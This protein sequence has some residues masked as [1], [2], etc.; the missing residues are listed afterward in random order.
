MN[1]SFRQLVTV[2]A[3]LCASAAFGQNTST[4]GKIVAGAATC[5]S[6][7]CVYYQLPPATPWVVVTVS[8]TWSGTINLAS[9]SAPNANYYNLNSLAWNQ[10]ASTTANGSWSI[11]TGGATFLLIY[12]P[13][14]SSGAASVTMTSSQTGSPLSNPVFLGAITGDGFIS[15]APS[16][17]GSTPLLEY[18]GTC[19]AGTPGSGITSI[20][21]ALPS[22]LSASPSTLNASGTQTFASATGL[23][24]HEVIGT[25]GTATTVSLCA[26]TLG[27]IGA[28]AAPSGLYDFSSASQLKHPVAAGYTS[29]AN[30]E[31]GY[32]STNLNWH[33]WQNGVDMLF[34]FLPTSGL[35]SGDCVEFLKTTNSWSLED[36]GAACGSGGGG[37]NTALSNLASVNIN[38]A[39][40]PQTSIDLG[41]TTKPFRNLY[42]YGSSTYGTDYFELTG[43]PTSTRTWT[44]QDATD[45]VVGRAT[46]DALTNKSIAATE[47][48]SGTLAC[49]QMPA[50]TGDATSSAGACATTVVQIEGAAIPTSAAFVATNGSKQFVAAAYTPA[51]CT[52]GTTGSDCLQLSSGLVPTGNL[53]GYVADTTVTIGSSVAFSA[54]ACSS[55]TGVSG[56]ASTVSMSGLATTMT[57]T[58]TPNSDVHSVTGW[59]PASGGQLYFTAWPSASGTLSYYVC[60]GT[61][62][63]ITTGGSVTWNV[64][65]R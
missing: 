9:I 30:G 21:W 58:F 26:P 43:N 12:A 15:T 20:A 3:L 41:S 11:A 4:F 65:A 63:T 36:A 31:F 56:T 50:L 6:A 55:A 24:P 51:N 64:S 19:V 62:S 33:G 49:A 18:N 40:T 46:T 14:W 34:A 1:R 25:C 16:C 23:T 28:G 61:G 42:L 22:W 38:A 52:A 27:D 39:L 53:P 37:A 54:N 8:G 7:N 44:F 60:N 17:S 45:T 5:Q 32:D 59:S 13:S 47:V 35:T 57:A 10:M 29:A 2:T 48:N